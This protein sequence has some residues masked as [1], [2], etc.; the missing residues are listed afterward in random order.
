MMKRSETKRAPWPNRKRNET[1]RNETTGP[2]RQQ[3][4]N[5]KRNETKRN[6]T[7]L[8]P[9]S[10]TRSARRE[11]RDLPN[12]G[13]SAPNLYII[14]GTLKTKRN[15]IRYRQDLIKTKRNETKY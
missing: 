12:T 6:G 13:G 3:R 14:M 15:E 11:P 4:V 2:D 10:R 5:V 9:E 8:G 1:K 7:S